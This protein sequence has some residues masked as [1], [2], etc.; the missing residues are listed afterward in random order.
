MFEWKT[1]VTN[2]V[3]CRFPIIQGA[4][5]GFGTAAIAGPVSKAGALGIITAGACRT[6]E[7]L[8]AEIEKVRAMTDNP[9]GVNISVGLVRD[10]VGMLDV[11]IDCKV[12]VLFTAAYKAED[13]GQRAK[14]AGIPWIHK[15]ATVKHALAGERQGADAVV[16]VGIEGSGF[17]SVTQLPTLI[18]ITTAAKL[19]KVPVIAAGGIGDAQGFLAALSMGAEAAYM[20]TAFMATTECEISDRYKQVLVDS[21]PWDQRVRDRALAPPKQEEYDR[22]MKQRDSIPKDEWLRKL[23]MVVNKQPADAEPASLPRE[24]EDDLQDAPEDS[25]QA[26]RNSGGSL[27]VGVIDE[28]KSVQALIEGIISGAERILEGSTPRRFQTMARAS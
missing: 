10:P 27:A 24:W 19:L 3:G 11:V 2:L 28:I 14:A 7:A 9:F 26:F 21:Q 25:E 5:G 6:P 20:G 1:R 4:Y 23:E 12:P 15:V 17:K 16:I 13:L 8:R 22:I 18:N